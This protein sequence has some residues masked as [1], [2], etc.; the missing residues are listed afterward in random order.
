[1]QAAMDFYGWMVDSGAQV[2]QASMES[3]ISAQCHVSDEGA[4][5]NLLSIMKT[6]GMKPSLSALVPFVK[7]RARTAESVDTILAEIDKIRQGFALPHPALHTFSKTN[8]FI[9][10]NR[11]MLPNADAFEPAFNFLAGKQN[12]EAMQTLWTKMTN[13]SILPS[14][15]LVAVFLLT[16]NVELVRN[17]LAQL[18]RQRVDIAWHIIFRKCLERKQYKSLKLLV[19][20]FLPRHTALMNNLLHHCFTHKAYQVGLDLFE[21]MLSLGFG[22]DNITV[23]ITINLAGGAKNVPLA[24]RFVV[25]RRNLPC[26]FLNFI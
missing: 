20:K 3:L 19:E 17:A 8:I 5:Q 15:S 7:L 21:R 22:P 11:G 12:V 4:A 26:A 1:M 14:P 23:P 6:K 24:L 13:L 9:L 10:R 16:E 25:L 2:D 18:K